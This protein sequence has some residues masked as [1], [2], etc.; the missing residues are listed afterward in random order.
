[1]TLAHGVGRIYESPLPLWL[2]L[3]GAAAVIAF[4]HPARLSF[5]TNPTAGK[6][7]YSSRRVLPV[8]SCRCCAS[9][10]SSDWCLR[11]SRVRSTTAGGLTFPLLL[12]WIVLIVGVTVVVRP[13]GRNV[14]SDRSVG[15]DRAIAA[16]RSRDGGGDT[17]SMVARTGPPLSALLVRA[18]PYMGLRRYRCRGRA[19]RL[20]GL[21]AR[22]PVRSSE[23]TGPWPIL[24]RFSTATPPKVRRCASGRTG[25]STAA[26]SPHSMIRTPRHLSVFAGVFLLLGS[27]TLDNVRETVG[28]GNTL[29]STGLDGLPGEVIDSVALIVLSAAFF[30]AYA[31]TIAIAHRWVGREQSFLVVARQIR[32]GRWPRS[33]SPTCSR[34]TPPL[35]MTGLPKLVAEMSDPLGLGWNLL[36]T[37][38]VFSTYIPSPALVWVLE[39]VLIVGGHIMGV[40]AA[41]RMA[42]RLAPDRSSAIRSQYSLTAADDDLHGDDPVAAIPTPDRLTM[43]ELSSRAAPLRSGRLLVRRSRSD[44][45]RE[46]SARLRTSVRP[47]PE[48]PT[49]ADSL[50]RVKA[51]RSS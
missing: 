28:W 5:P 8:S 42:L 31:L 19:R 12:F 23:T 51:S 24:S 32:V 18:G 15:D 38:N 46:A 11:S 48:P 1:M 22:V 17:A 33:G 16:R 3:A 44:V 43:P 39:I 45:L 13:R 20:H 21:R 34:T 40:L 36:G 26:R 49:L 27:T 7:G 9:S 47:R 14:V 50:P 30:A 25:C 37:R 35:L 29:R 2:Y 10:R 4:L 6:S 41:H